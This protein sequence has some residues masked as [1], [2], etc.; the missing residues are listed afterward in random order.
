MLEALETCERLAKTLL[1]TWEDFVGGVVMRHLPIVMRVLEHEQH[2]RNP[3]V[4][5]FPYIKLL[6]SRSYC[7]CYFFVL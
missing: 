5:M 2:P 4:I 1:A 7:F 3:P 6:A